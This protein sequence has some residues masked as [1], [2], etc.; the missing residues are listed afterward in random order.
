MKRG[1]FM[2]SWLILLTVFSMGLLSLTVLAYSG[3][4]YFPLKVAFQ[5]NGYAPP[6]ITAEAT[7]DNEPE[8]I[9][10]A[11]LD[12]EIINGDFVITRTSAG[13]N[14]TLGDGIDEETAWEFDFSQDPNFNN[15]PSAPLAFARLEL[16]L[17][18]KSSLV[19]FDIVRIEGLP[20]ITNP[21][22]FQGL[23]VDTPT[24]VEIELLDFYSSDDILQVLS[25]GGQIPMVYADDSIVPFARL[26]LTPEVQP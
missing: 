3:L 12:A 4:P 13:A 1:L 26:T 21:P 19:A 20:E 10:N 11:G 5:Q 8:Q 18:P 2:R 17:I 24:T 16:T 23:P 22:A 15:F 6:T 25:E 9:V 14:T 7:G